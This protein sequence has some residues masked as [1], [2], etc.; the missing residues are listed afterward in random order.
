MSPAHRS[1]GLRRYQ[2]AGLLSLIA[3]VVAAVLAVG[4][5]ASGGSTGNRL[6]A[7]VVPATTGPL[8][9]GDSVWN[10]IYVANG[11]GPQTPPRRG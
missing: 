7:Y 4:A 6:F 5:T 3:I 10:Y 11:I 8:H 9:V 1:A 2:S